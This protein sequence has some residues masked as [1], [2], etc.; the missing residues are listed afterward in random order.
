LGAGKFKIIVRASPVCKVKK[1]KLLTEKD[2]TFKD[3][4]TKRDAYRA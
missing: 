4:T 2:A 1:Q 3:F